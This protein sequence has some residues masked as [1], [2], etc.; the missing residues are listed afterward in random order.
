M[1]LEPAF[2]AV[3]LERLADMGLEPKLTTVAREEERHD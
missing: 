1:E 2:V 3:G